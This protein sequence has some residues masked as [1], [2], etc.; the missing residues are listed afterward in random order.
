M[1]K[2]KYLFKEL[3]VDSRT[4][5]NP[6]KNFKLGHG[7]NYYITIKDIHDGEVV[8]TDKT[9]RIDDDAMKIINK[10]SRLKVGDVLF[11]SIGRIGETAIIREEPKN[12]NINESVFAFTMNKSLITPEFFRWM[13]KSTKYKTEILRESTGSTFIS[14]KMN[15][16]N[17]MEFEIPSIV[18]QSH[19]VDEL[20]NLETSLKNC[21]SRLE[22][23]NEMAESRFHEMFGKTS[24]TIT[25]GES[26]EV[27]ARIGWQALTQ[28]EYLA[29]GKY[30]LITGTDFIENEVN[31]S[32]CVYVSEDRY[33]MDRH[34][35]LKNDDVLITKDGTIGKVA[36]V[37]NLPGPATLNGGIFVVRPN[38]N[39]FN[40]EYISYVF[41]AN[42][43]SQ[44]IELVKTGVAV[45]HLNQEALNKFEIPMPPLNEQKVFAE[46]IETIDK[47][48]EIV[49]KESAGLRE[50]LNS[51][52]D[53][54]FGI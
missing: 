43:F 17:D 12:W 25:V 24:T 22:K 51:K 27:H 3:V 21:E 26:C 35:I 7:D 2:K 10:R 30:M 41:K 6:R 33:N 11:S 53:Y 37:H 4:G 16:L 34:I 20:N 5:L 15:K 18:E 23:L 39:I 52:I 32:T 13:F 36:I 50:L 29:T 42:T 48:K 28:K 38:T 46:Y 44:Y 8:I 14:I 54:Y 1:E 49:K 31:Y 45:K 19:I 9:E 47:L 40:K